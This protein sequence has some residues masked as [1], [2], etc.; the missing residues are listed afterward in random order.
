MVVSE[1]LTVLEKGDKLTSFEIAEQLDC[2]ITAVK[3]GMKRLLKDISENVEFR[4][5]TPEE[6]ELKYGHKI[7]CRIHIYWLNE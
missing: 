7:S 3:K 1:I 6:K 2:S 4:R 5:L